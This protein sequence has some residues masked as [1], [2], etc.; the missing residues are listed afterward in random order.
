VTQRPP[1]GYVLQIWSSPNPQGFDYRQY[2]TSKRELRDFEGI[3]LVTI[4]TTRKK[5]KGGVQKAPDF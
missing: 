4:K 5:K 3:A 2:G 1:L